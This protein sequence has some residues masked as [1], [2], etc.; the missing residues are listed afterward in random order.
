[1][2]CNTAV[3]TSNTIQ[4]R[5]EYPRQHVE[6]THGHKKKRSAFICIKSELE[7]YVKGLYQGYINVSV[8]KKQGRNPKLH[9]STSCP[10][11]RYHKT[12]HLHHISPISLTTL[13]H[14]PLP[15]VL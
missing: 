12:H 7:N 4:Q 8:Q 9:A 14:M 15:Y 11:N 5:R 13:S 6:P 10:G 2:F 3:K 1:M